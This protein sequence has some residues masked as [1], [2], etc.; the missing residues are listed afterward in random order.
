MFNVVLPQHPYM[1]VERDFIMVFHSKY[2]LTENTEFL[3]PW[4]LNWIVR[5]FNQVNPLTVFPAVANVH[6]LMYTNICYRLPYTSILPTVLHL[7][8]A[9][10]NRYF[11]TVETNELGGAS[12]S[13]SDSDSGCACFESDPGKI[14]WQTFFVFFL[15]LRP[16]IVGIVPFTSFLI[17]CSFITRL[18]GAYSQ[19]YWKRC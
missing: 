18:F 2:Y 19:V 11:T 10:L 8:H 3:M 6:I 13:A 1:D 9:V 15:S 4:D 14:H 7:I 12:D 5:Q 17:Q 16:V